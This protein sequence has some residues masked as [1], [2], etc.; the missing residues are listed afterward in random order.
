M[1]CAENRDKG[2]NLFEHFKNIYINTIRTKQPSHFIAGNRKINIVHT[3][4]R[5][6]CILSNNL[7]WRN[8]I[9][10]PFCFCGQIKDSYHFLFSGTLNNQAK[11]VSNEPLKIDQMNII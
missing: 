5:H 11:T 3:K 2:G 10:F 6:N 9:G 4:L 1:K 8:I 7:F